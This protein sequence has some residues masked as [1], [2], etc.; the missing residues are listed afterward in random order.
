MKF[1]II[2][3]AYNEEGAIEAIIMRCLEARDGITDATPVES[4]E[5]IVVS[6]GSSDGTTEISRRYQPEVRLIEYEKNRGYGAAIKTGFAEATGDI[7]GFL[8]ADGTCDPRFFIE[9]LNRLEKEG[10][11]LCLG[12]RLG[13]GSRMPMVRRLGNLCYRYLVTFLAYKIG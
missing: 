7:V 3:P 8:D 6:D 12:S 11:D 5:I 9:L 4:V 13:P 10:T 1:S 2:I